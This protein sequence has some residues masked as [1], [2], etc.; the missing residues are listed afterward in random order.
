[1]D[2]A[3]KRSAEDGLVEYR[4]SFIEFALAQGVLRFGD[5]TAKSGRQTPYFFDAGR[6]NTGHALT[7][8]GRAYAETIVASGVEY[9][10]L[11]GPAYKGIPLVCSAAM[12]LHTHHSRPSPY[13]FNR[14]E[15]KDHGE[16][17][18]IVGTP[19]Q[20]GM[21]VLIVDDVMTAGTAVRESMD[22]IK[23]AGCHLA[24]VVIAL[25]R[26]ER[27]KAEAEGEAERGG[28]APQSAVQEVAGQ[29]G[30]PVLSIITLQHLITYLDESVSRK[31]EGYEDLDKTLNRIRQYLD[32]YGVV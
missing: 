24:G 10:V 9:D 25:D 29:Y 19:L 21:R 28:A 1:M 13:A 20:R 3:E 26:Q 23:R 32:K 2:K 30:V 5:F 18:M 27:G 12:A 15:A 8:L 7:C 22:I 16:G 4:R 6:F 31:D 17:G 14:K 11:F